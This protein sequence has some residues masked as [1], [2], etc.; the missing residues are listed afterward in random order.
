MGHNNRYQ[1]NKCDKMELVEKMDKPFKL[2]NQ[3]QK[4]LG[5]VLNGQSL[6][7]V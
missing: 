6:A 4:Q 7:A 1:Q 5:C 2:K 3:G